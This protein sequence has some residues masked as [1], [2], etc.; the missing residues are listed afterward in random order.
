MVIPMNKSSYQ[1]VV[2]GAS[3][4]AMNAFSILL[5]HLPADFPVPVVAVCHRQR[6]PDN[7][8]TEYLASICAMKVQD[9]EHLES[10]KP[11]VIYIA[12]PGYHVLIDDDY[13]FNLSLDLPVNYSRPSIDVFFE[14]VAD[15][16][17]KQAIAIILTGANRDGAAGLKQIKTAGGYTI[18]Q[19]PKT[20]ETPFMP[21]AAI[22]ESQIDFVGSLDEIAK[23][24]CDIFSVEVRPYD[25]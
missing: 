23:H 11:G 25:K 10:I 22:K 16:Y 14:T 1:I 6:S 21:E 17:G 19:D 5:A 9:V 20:A 12:P 15:I 18:V 3:A 2:V 8:L 7:F 13:T 24:L 4:G